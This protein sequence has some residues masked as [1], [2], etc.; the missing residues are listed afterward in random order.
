MPA[1]ADV[2]RRSAFVGR[3]AERARLAEVLARGAGAPAVLLLQG[4]SGIGKSR[5]I[6]EALSG[7]IAAEDRPLVL[8]GSPY[9]TR[10]PFQPVR[11]ALARAAGLDVAE[12][13][14]ERQAR[15]EAL[16]AAT[17]GATPE[18]AALL[19]TLLDGDT[20]EDAAAAPPGQ[21]AD[22]IRLLGEVLAALAARHAV[23]IAEDAHWLDPS[24]AEL[25]RYLL[26]GLAA[27]SIALLAT[28]R[29]G[30]V[31]TWLAPPVSEV[32]QVAPL[33]AAD[34][35]ALVAG[36]GGGSVPEA[37]AAAIGA[38][39]QGIPLLAEELARGY[40][41]ARAEGGGVP[42]TLAE[43]L[44]ARLGRLPLGRRIATLAAAIGRGFPRAVLV[45]L[46]GL[47]PNSTDLAIADLVAAGLIAPSIGPFGPSLRFRHVMVRDA[48]YA[49]LTGEEAAALH[50]RIADTLEARFPEI[51]RAQPQMMAMQRHAAGQH[52]TAAAEWS[53]AGRGAFGRSAYAEAVG[54]HRQA[55]EALAATEAGPARDEAELEARL[56]LMGALICA[57]GYLAD[58]A[59]AETER[60]VA[61]AE[62]LGGRSRLMPAMQ[63]R[64]VQLGAANRVRASRDFARQVLVATA[65]EA[66]VDRLIAHRMCGTSS[67]FCGDLAD[68]LRHYRAFVA[69]FDPEGHAE[70]MRRGHSDHAAF[71]MLGLSEVHTLRGE[72]EDADEW[73]DRVRDWT[74]HAGRVH[75]EC[76]VL[77]FSILHACLL[78]RWEEAREQTDELVRMTTGHAL[79]NW[80]GYRDLFDGVLR[81]REGDAE[82]G[83]AGA[84]RGIDALLAARAFGNWWYLLHAEACIGAAAWAEAEDTLAR[85]RT[86]MELGDTRFG[87]EYHRLAA[88]LARERDGDAGAAARELVAGLELADQQGA[89]LLRGHLVAD[90]A[91]LP[92]EALPPGA[93]GLMRGNARAT[94]SPRRW[95]GGRV[96]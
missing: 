26:P 74:R 5:L 10:S 49:L 58:D 62:R 24:T 48:V 92:P 55:L 80:T 73:R 28:A 30:P 96:V 20:A 61:L 9:A 14:E 50:A 21:R 76:H 66:V 34:T 88:R 56:N 69:L 67:L 6:R 33:G 40:L 52:A 85:F 13:P 47:P 79:P 51:A 7:R 70:A 81:C 36:L 53:R 63:A 68:A 95:T 89:A 31:P 12:A 39:A 38:H 32:I 11:H 19:A 37:A 23:L 78:R 4:P 83:L 94:A 29:P 84:R 82:A 2:P 1:P 72:T 45:E 86:I 18:N 35:A 42:R 27:R 90:L 91:A 17:A 25:V 54:F 65:H 16:L 87:A 15:I 93:A 64:W 57:E 71:V 77:A 75:D 59:A 46:A 22:L 41:D 44:Q 3:Q 60:A 8:Q 43:A